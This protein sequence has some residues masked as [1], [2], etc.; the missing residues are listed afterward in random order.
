MRIINEQNKAVTDVNEITAECT[1]NFKSI[2]S[3][4]KDEINQVET[5]LL[6]KGDKSN[7]A[8]KPILKSE[9][10]NVIKSL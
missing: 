3:T 7:V 9:I 8:Y 4:N 6:T 2:Y 1:K 10:E 5:K